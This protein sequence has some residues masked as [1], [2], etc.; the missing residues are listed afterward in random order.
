MIIHILIFILTFFVFGYIITR[1]L[2]KFFSDVLSQSERLILGLGIA[3]L[4]VSLILFFL[5]LIIPNKEGAV[6][7]AGVF[8]VFLLI[9]L[10]TISTKEKQVAYLPLISFKKL[11]KEQKDFLVFLV[12][13]IAVMGYIFFQAIA[14]PISSHDGTVYATMGRI[15]SREKNLNNFPTKVPDQTGFYFSGGQHPPGLPLIYAW[16]NFLSGTDSDYFQRTVSPM[17][18]LYLLILLWLVLKERAMNFKKKST[19][20]APIIGVILLLITPAFIW[21]AFENSIDPLRMFFVFAS[22]VI[23]WK[24]I[25]EKSFKLLILLGSVSGLALYSHASSTLIFAILILL[26]M[27]FLPFH[28]WKKVSY[29]L[30]FACVVVVIGGG[31]YIINYTRFNNILGQSTYGLTE[32]KVKNFYSSAQSAFVD[33]AGSL[34]IAPK[35]SLSRELIFGRL[36][37]FARP[38]LFGISYYLFIL[39]LIYWLKT[40]RKEKL[41]KIFL[42]GFLLFAIPVIY[43]FYLNRRY[44]LTVQPIVVYFGSIYAGQIYESLKKKKMAKWF[45]AVLLVIFLSIGGILLAQGSIVSKLVS[46]GG[47]SQLDYFLSNKDKRNKI[48]APGTF[49]AI[50]FIKQETPKDSVI[51]TFDDSRFFYFAER[52][53]IYMLSPQLASFYFASNGEEAYKALIDLKVDYIFVDVI[54]NELYIDKSSLIINFLNNGHYSTLVFDEHSKVYKL[55]K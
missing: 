25:Q 26:L 21:Q 7:V 2:S 29:T 48:I 24:T 1:L 20:Y 28:F 15:L 39:A 33:Q 55:I 54:N 34:T 10:F 49:E 46:K 44:I 16:G 4:L 41:D 12:L 11:M 22:F 3:P 42:A 47:S 53:G 52:K 27:F 35:I 40:K 43:K 32:I 18:A 51:L 31:Q 36:Q 19:D 9:L 17:Y 14:F 23:L 13:S 30:I 5:F 45:W 50:D 37:V 8:I 6:Y 38:E